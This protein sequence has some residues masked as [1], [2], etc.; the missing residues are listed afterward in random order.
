MFHKKSTFM[1][2]L[3]FF[4]FEIFFPL[5]CKGTLKSYPAKRVVHVCMFV[6]VLLL[7]YLA[8]SCVRSLCKYL[9]YP[10]VLLSLQVDNFGEEC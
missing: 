10:S 6:H 9:N 5:P 1:S 8:L 4:C 7:K 2:C 3:T